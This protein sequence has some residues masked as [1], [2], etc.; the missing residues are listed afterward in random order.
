MVRRFVVQLGSG[1]PKVG[2]HAAVQRLLR[3]GEAAGRGVRLGGDARISAAAAA[4]QRRRHRRPD[5]AP[6]QV[7]ARAH[8]AD[9]RA[10]VVAHL[11]RAA[12]AA[13][14][15]RVVAVHLPFVA[16]PVD[17]KFGRKTRDFSPLDL[18]RV[19]RRSRGGKHR[20]N[21]KLIRHGTR[22]FCPLPEHAVQRCRLV[23]IA[24]PQGFDSGVD[25]DEPLKLDAAPASS[26]ASP[27][28]RA[29]CTRSTRTLRLPLKRSGSS[30]SGG[31]RWSSTWAPALPAAMCCRDVRGLDRGVRG[32]GAARRGLEERCAGWRASCARPRSRASSRTRTSRRASRAASTRAAPTSS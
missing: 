20:R 26:A 9:A 14:G 22:S 5:G 30:G 28:P 29:R 12:A 10:P 25:L 27:R 23:R 6:R 24:E 19:S 31:G 8:A 2:D 15:E 3:A 16:G 7:G 11:P 21:A 17:M 4:Q 1:R 18:A 13:V 32:E